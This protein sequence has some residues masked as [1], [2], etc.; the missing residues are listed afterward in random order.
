MEAIEQAFPENLR[1]LFPVLFFPIKLMPW[2]VEGEL[3]LVCLKV[4]FLFLP[5]LLLLASFWCSLVGLGTVVFRGEK[6]KFTATILITWWDGGRSVFQYWAGI[7]R[8]IFYSVGWIFG[9]IRLIAVGL[10]QTFKDV[11]LL[12]L[13]TINSL[14]KSYSAPG[15]PWVAVLFTSFWIIGESALFSLILSPVVSGILE[16]MTGN[17][18]PDIFVVVGLFLFLLMI[19]GGSMACMHGLVLAIESG[20]KISIIK[21]AVVEFVVMAMEVIFFYREFVEAI[22]PFFNRMMDSDAGIPP[23]FILIIAGGAWLG[24]RASTWF[25]FGKYG[26]PTLLAIIS[27]EGMEVGSGK[28][29]QSNLPSAP[30]GWIKG[31]VA[32]LQNELHWFSEKGEEIVSY[33]VLPPVQIL[34]VITNFFMIL[35]TGRHLFTLPIKTMDDLKNTTQMIQ[36]VADEKRR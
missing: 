3:H 25:F 29:N 21:M 14:A 16:S 7:F 8:F 6:A 9:A 12:P 19:V 28:S 4:T 32:Q 17:Q 2:L 11:F 24:V 22:I 30:L 23:I 18:F 1:F 26:T 20:N 34:A 5:I 15:M 31:L 36:E 13:Y 27:R 10:V 33:F 35:I